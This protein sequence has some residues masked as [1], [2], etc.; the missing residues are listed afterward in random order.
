MRTTLDIDDDVLQAAKERARRE[1]RT[2]GDVISELAR[3]AL[4]APPPSTTSEPEAFY[5][6]RPFPSRGRVITNELIDRIREEDAY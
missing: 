1:R 2:A 6:F 5:G 4:T 3:Q